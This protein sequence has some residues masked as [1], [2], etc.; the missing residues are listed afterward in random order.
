M[1]ISFDI[2][3][4]INE[5][6]KTIITQTL[7]SP[8]YSLETVFFN[9]RGGLVKVLMEFQGV[10]FLKMDILNRGDYFYFWKSPMI[11]Q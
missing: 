11:R 7:G 6:K 4:V 9:S 8:N 1:Y 3:Q 5:N 2:I 10:Q